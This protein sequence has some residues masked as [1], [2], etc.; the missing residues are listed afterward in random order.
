MKKKIIT[1]LVTGVLLI[2]SQT[3]A[4]ATVTC[5]EKITNV[6]VHSNGQIYFQTDQTCSANWCQLNWGYDAKLLDRGY[7][8]ILTAKTTGS[9]VAIEWPA[10]PN[11]TSQNQ[12]YA[13]PGFVQLLTP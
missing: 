11:C 7:A 9:T 3:Y 6:T 10:I 8:V 1:I 2:L 12:V 4:H 13:S 5:C